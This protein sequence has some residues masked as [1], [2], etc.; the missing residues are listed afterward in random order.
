M[1]Y[2]AARTVPLQKLTVNSLYPGTCAVSLG[3]SCVDLPPRRKNE[4]EHVKP[5][6]FERA[7]SSS[8]DNGEAW[9]SIPSASTRLLSKN[10][11][12]DSAG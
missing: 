3:V 9:W 2:I 7:A 5:M 1:Q 4:Y 8:G 6:G 10:I 11:Q 12:E